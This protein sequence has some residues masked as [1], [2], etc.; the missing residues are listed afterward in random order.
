M[1]PLATTW[2]IPV[3]IRQH[4]T[5]FIELLQTCQIGNVQCYLIGNRIMSSFEITD[6]K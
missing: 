1:F 4:L 6:G 2:E 3:Y 5:L